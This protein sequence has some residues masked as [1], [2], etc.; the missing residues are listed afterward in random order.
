MALH[1]TESKNM[2][3]DGKWDQKIGHVLVE[4]DPASM[5]FMT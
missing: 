5:K 1:V 2:L 4:P 3:K